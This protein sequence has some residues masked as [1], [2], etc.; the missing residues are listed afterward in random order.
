MRSIDRIIVASL[1]V[2]VIA[3]GTAFAVFSFYDPIQAAANEGAKEVTGA[4]VP[5]QFNFQHPLSELEHDLYRFHNFLLGINIAIC[6]L[7]AALV[8]IAM[9]L[10]R[11]SR[12]PNAARTTHN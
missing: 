1:V 2:A 12:H 5:W 6:G 7:V 9:W 4:P 8:A 11:A 10:F 3:V